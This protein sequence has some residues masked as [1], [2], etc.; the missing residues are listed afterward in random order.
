MA[1]KLYPK[2][3]LDSLGICRVGL[4]IASPVLY[5]QMNAGLSCRLI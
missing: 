2:D 4:E 1:A 3:S 5:L